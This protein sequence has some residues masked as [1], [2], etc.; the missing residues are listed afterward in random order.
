[1]RRCTGEITCIFA[2][3]IYQS[4]DNCNNSKE[5]NNTG[6]YRQECIPSP[7]SLGSHIMRSLSLHRNRRL[8]CWLLWLDRLLTICCLLKCISKS[9]DAWITIILVLTQCLENDILHRMWNQRILT[10]Q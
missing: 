8:D 5:T 9:L 4:N 10:S 7:V 6:N 3:S 2:S 1:M